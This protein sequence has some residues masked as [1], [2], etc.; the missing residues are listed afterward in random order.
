MRP[1]LTFNSLLFPS[2]I[3]VKKASASEDASFNY[4]TTITIEDS[5]YN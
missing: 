2:G 1:G 4:I 5:Y 3:I